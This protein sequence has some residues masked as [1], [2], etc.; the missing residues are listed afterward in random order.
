[1]ARYG[2]ALSDN[3]N[4]IQ[5]TFFVDSFS[6]GYTL[7]FA[8]PNLPDINFGT[9]TDS[10]L[11]QGLGIAGQTFNAANPAQWVW[12]SGAGQTPTA[13]I[14]LRPQGSS[15]WFRTAQLDFQL[16]ATDNITLKGGWDWKNFKFTSFESRR[17]LPGTQ[18]NNEFQ[19]PT[20]AQVNAIGG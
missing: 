4:P 7:N 6:S 9:L 15:N 2:S 20:T 19:V 18:T 1:D 14:R 8:N 11:Y 17:F 12:R 5:T 13:E 10:P 16:D 3:K